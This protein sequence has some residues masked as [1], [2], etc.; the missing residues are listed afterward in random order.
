MQPEKKAKPHR[1]AV[2]INTDEKFSPPLWMSKLLWKDHNTNISGFDKWFTMF[3]NRVLWRHL[4]AGLKWDRE[5]QPF[6]T[7]L[8]VIVLL[9]IIIIIK[10]NY[11]SFSWTTG[12]RCIAAVRRYPGCVCGQT[13][14]CVILCCKVFGRPICFG[15]K[16]EVTN[17]LSY[18][19]RIRWKDIAFH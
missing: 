8:T 12:W 11:W 4:K 18:N 10:V 19:Q 14:R 2:I 6:I 5:L 9:L 13:E 3:I 1:M 7:V 17:N 15:W 16:T